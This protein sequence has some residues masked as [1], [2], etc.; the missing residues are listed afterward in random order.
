MGVKNSNTLQMRIKND[1]SQIFK[2]ALFQVLCDFIRKFIASF[3]DP[4]LELSINDALPFGKAPKVSAERA[5]FLSH[6]QKTFRVGNNRAD[7]TLGANHSRRFQ[8]SPNILF[9]KFR[10]LLKIKIGKAL[11]KD[12]SFRKHQHPRKAT[13]HRFQEQIF[14]HFPVIMNRKSP[15]LIVISF[16]Y[17]VLQ[18]PVARRHFTK[19]KQIGR[20]TYKKSSPPQSKEAFGVSTDGAQRSRQ[21]PKFRGSHANHLATKHP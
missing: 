19:Q 16:R 6:I 14:E 12:I 9:R 3:Q 11:G 7:F 5:V 8:N 4:F 15:F 18:K 1:T 10:H 2:S 20:A 17:R 21:F 13:A